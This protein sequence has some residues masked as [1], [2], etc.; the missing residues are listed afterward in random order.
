MTS[1]LKPEDLPDSSSPIPDRIVGFD[2]M[3]WLNAVF[4]MQGAL[5]SVINLEE[6]SRFEDEIKSILTTKHSDLYGAVSV[7]ANIPRNDQVEL[8]EAIEHIKGIDIYNYPDEIAGHQLIYGILSRDI[9]YTNFRISEQNYMGKMY[10]L[11]AKR[12]IY[13]AERMLKHEIENEIILDILFTCGAYIAQ[14]MLLLNFEAEEFKEFIRRKGASLNRSLGHQ[15]ADKE[16]EE[17]IKM[18]CRMWDNDKS[19]LKHHQMAEYLKQQPQFL[20]LSQIKLK[21]KLKLYAEKR[22]MKYGP[23]GVKESR[24][25]DDD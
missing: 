5:S 16:Y 3:H 25:L 24:E 8:Y 15:K 11:K 7:Y 1:E 10:A 12:N 19:E 17:A 22:G 9:K 6:L 23:K 18:A 21:N 2:V 13:M 20:E 4:N 14:A